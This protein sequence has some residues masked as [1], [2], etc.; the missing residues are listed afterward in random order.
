MNRYLIREECIFCNHKLNYHLFDNDLKTYVSHYAVEENQDVHLIPYNILICDKCNT[1]QIKYLGDIGEVYKVN[2][3]DG[4]GSTM[5]MMHETKLKLLLK[6]K[7]KVNGILEIGS[8]KGILSDLILENLKTDYYIVEPFYFGS[9]TGKYIFDDYYENIDDTQI[10]ANTLIMSHVFEH[11]YNPLIILEKIKNNTNIE[12]I[13]LTFPNFEQYI[14]EDIH[15]VVN[16]EHTFYVDNKFLENL[17]YNYGFKLVETNLY[18]SHSI[19]F[20]FSRS[21]DDIQKNELTNNLDNFYSYFDR[22]K[23][24]VNKFNQI[25]NQNSHRNIYMFPASCHSIFFSIF[26]LEYQKLYGMVD[27]SPNKIGKKVYGLDT[28]I[29][30]FKEVVKGKDNPIILINGGIFNEEIE[31]ELKNNNIEYYSV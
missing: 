18:K 23:S 10:E 14:V 22:L 13:F 20:Y 2:H 21:S 6:Y 1:P 9:R 17:F 27:N 3:A 7:D 26:G 25:I 4:T 31:D 19:I 8:S 29:Y 28:K 12:N 16:T 5:K 24:S 11:F 30:S 15:H